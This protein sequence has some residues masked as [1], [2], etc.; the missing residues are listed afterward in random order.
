MGW[1]TEDPPVGV[2]I[3][4]QRGDGLTVRGVLLPC[5]EVGSGRIAAA[6]RQSTPLYASQEGGNPFKVLRWQLPDDTSPL[7][8]RQG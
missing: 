4:Y 7:E 8:D 6:G 1:K 3:I 2:E 5:G